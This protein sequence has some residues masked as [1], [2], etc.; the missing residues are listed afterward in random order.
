VVC[1]ISVLSS[2]NKTVYSNSFYTALWNL[3]DYS[4][5]VFP[6]TTVDPELDVQVEGRHEFY[7]Y[8]DEAVYNWC[9]RT[10]HNILTTA[11]DRLF[12][13]A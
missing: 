13:F 3:L 6:V 12:P 9:K 4:A 7:N 8:E 1:D 11:E 10:S 2:Y 5:I